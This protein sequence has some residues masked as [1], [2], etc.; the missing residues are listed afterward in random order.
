MFGA[1]LARW[2]DKR[3][4][5]MGE[6]DG[7]TVV[8]VGA[9]PGTLARAVLAAQP[10][11][12]ATGRYVTVEVSA[13]QRALHPD[14][15]DA[16]AEMPAGPL[17]GAVVANELL[18]NLPFGVLAADGESWRPVQVTV[19][20]DEFFEVLGDPVNPPVALPPVAGQR[21]PTQA[22]AAQWVA[23]AWASLAPGSSLLVV[24][25][26]ATTAQMAQKSSW[27]RTYRNHQHGG[28]PLDYL[29][30]QDITT[31]V[32]VDQLP[33]QPEVGT[34]LDWLQA[35]GIDDL[36]AEGRRIWE[37]RAGVADLV[38]LKARSRVSEAEAL[39]APDGLGA[40][41]PLTWTPPQSP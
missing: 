17:V 31:E 27:L 41:Q 13:A 7:F 38:A 10:A 11:C 12:L 15:V 35:N 29:G 21:I 3:W 14:G 28:S 6:P 25:Y 9:G 18:D 40:F 8:E 22:A 23:G 16:L 24:D 30:S 19:E 39:L 32:A 36:V 4:A 5:A 37:Q 34:Q 1:V 33:G 20:G 2:L 26:C